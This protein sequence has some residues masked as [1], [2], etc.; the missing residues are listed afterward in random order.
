MTR[1]P[2]S[3]AAISGAERQNAS[4]DELVSHLEHDSDRQRSNEPSGRTIGR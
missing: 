3:T 1:T 2:N 4:D